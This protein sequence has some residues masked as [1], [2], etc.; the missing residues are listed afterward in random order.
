MFEL[1]SA[2]RTSRSPSGA[3]AHLS[4]GGI[5]GGGFEIVFEV[6]P[7]CLSCQLVADG[8]VGATMAHEAMLLA[9][10]PVLSVHAPRASHRMHGS[11]LTGYSPRE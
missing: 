1:D 2:S 6:G 7:V 9:G 11:L 10:R 3:F 4:A 8:M 5:G